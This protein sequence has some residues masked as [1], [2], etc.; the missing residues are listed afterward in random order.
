MLPPVISVPSSQISYQEQRP[1]IEIAGGGHANAAAPQTVA[2]SA[3][4]QSAV[5][6]RLN[7]LL[8]SGRERMA[9]N[10]AMLAEIFGAAIGVTRKQGESSLAFAQR[11]A[12]AIAALPLPQRIKLEGQLARVLS[13]AQLRM[14]LAA[15]HNPD[16]ADAAKLSMLIE[17]A[18]TAERDLAAR[19]VVTSYRQNAA[20]AKSEPQDQPSH[21]K[22]ASPAVAAEQPSTADGAEPATTAAALPMPG[23]EQ[24]AADPTPAPAQKAAPGQEAASP[25]AK[26]AKPDLSENA[27]EPQEE[28]A[29]APAEMADGSNDGELATASASP[30]RLIA[31]RSDA[32]GLQ[33]LLQ[34]SF[35][36]ELPASAAEEPAQPASSADA[37]STI[38]AD[39]QLEA[40]SA[41]EEM[42]RA[43]LS[44]EEEYSP[45]S[46]LRRATDTA[47]PMDRPQ[48]TL[49]VL[50]GWQEV[51]SLPPLPLDDTAQAPGRTLVAQ[52]IQAAGG[53][54]LDG[55]G[56][57]IHDHAEPEALEQNRRASTG[58]GSWQDESIDAIDRDGPAQRSF[59]ETILSQW[60]ALE[61]QFSALRPPVDLPDS[62]VLPVVSYL[63][64][65]EA[66][67]ETAAEK[68]RR[69]DDEEAEEQQASGEQ[70]E[71]RERQRQQ[72]E[73]PAAE[74]TEEVAAD[75][76]S[77]ISADAERAND[78]YWRM[79]GWS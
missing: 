71:G 9:E 7:M 14:L 38:H 55:T 42:P 45:R 22:A 24:S 59:P 15:L 46:E 26:V 12:E 19:S 4:E 39:E 40:P 50:K 74:A 23:A 11:L 16:G 49:L 8:L 57:S 10:L 76:P 1:L 63:F 34:R 43:N 70:G 61:E 79:A 20:E 77:G 65:D 56:A 51:E 30:E 28:A 29:D 3:L 41:D 44:D 53:K 60:R 73:E 32:H 21:G 54:D 33:V 25:E 47:K 66:E 18:R 75:M 62:A 6:G 31:E 78:L 48:T 2:P 13:G 58:A 17:L 36:A 52:A 35:A 69:R 27:V 72:T 67:E 64:A 37:K 5:A 68:P